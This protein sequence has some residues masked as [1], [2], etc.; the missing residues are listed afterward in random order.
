MAVF[1]ILQYYLPLFERPDILEMKNIIALIIIDG[2]GLSVSMNGDTLFKYS[3]EI[4]ILKL[5]NPY[6][7]LSVTGKDISSTAESVNAETGYINI[8]AGRIMPD[9]STLRVENNF[10]EYISSLGLLQTKI[11]A[12]SHKKEVTYCLNGRD[13]TVLP[14]E[15]RMPISVSINTLKEDIPFEIIYK[16]EEAVQDTISSGESDVIII[17][18]SACGSELIN[19]NTDLTLRVLSAVDKSVG[20][21]VLLI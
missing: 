7:T 14:G 21:I 12:D 16:T 2:Y 19:G 1:V 9:D 18:I 10:S 4:D 5:N 8:T 15:T 3:P 20:K 6:T 13:E 17:S 11:Y